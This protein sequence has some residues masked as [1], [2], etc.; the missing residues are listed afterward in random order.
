MRILRALLFCGT[1]VAMPC[2]AGAQTAGAP[3]PTAAGSQVAISGQGDPDQSSEQD[4]GDIVVTA[5]RRDERL[6]DVPVSVTALSADQLTQKR[7]MGAVDLTGSVP[8]LQAAPTAGDGTPIFSLRGI[9]MS[10]Y[11]V[12][13]QSPVATYFDEVYKGSFPLLPTGLFDL[14]RVE[15]LRGPQ[16]TLYGKNTT[17]GAINFISRKPKIGEFEG[18]LRL[19]YGNYDRYEAD[20]AVNVPLGDAL[21]FRGAFTFARADGWFHN[22]LPGRRD[23][24]ATRQYALRGSLLFEPSDALSFV[25]RASTSLDNPVIYGVLG[26]PLADGVGAGVYE[27]FGGQSYFR[28]G[29]GRRETASDY[30]GEYR[31]RT[32]GIALNANWKLS[33]ALAITSVTSYDYGK[34]DI[35]EDAD[36]SPLQ[37]LHND[38]RSVAK[39]FAQDLRLA[40]DFSS[41][42]NFILGGYYNVERLRAGYEYRY[43]N[44]I[45]VNQ[46]GAITFE[47]CLVDF[48]LSCAYRNKFKQK[49]TSVAAYADLNWE[50]ADR[51][52]L[53]GGLRYTHDT[54]RLSDFNSLLFGAD[55]VPIANVIPGGPDFD[56]T[57]GLAFKK[58]NLSGKIGVDFKPSANQLIY[59]SYSRGYRANAFNAQALFDIAELNVARP[60]TVDAYELGFKSQFLNRSLTINGAA[61]YYAYEN[62]QALSIDQASL[63]NILYNIPRSRVLGGELEISARITSAFR[64]NASAGYLDSKIQRGLLNGADIAGNRLPNAPKL[65]ISGGVEADIFSNQTGTLTAAVDASF[66]S[67]KYFELSNLE[68]LTQGKYALLNARITF[69]TLDDRFSVS[70]WGKNITNRYYYNSAVDATAVGYD[71]FHAGTPR[72]YGVSLEAKF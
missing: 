32:N 28:T 38:V 2:A 22:V 25:L 5:L 6:Q 69:A 44:D 3:G 57:T 20:G 60:E 63:L 35:G 39:Q 48:F 31:H 46:D 59:A 34:L 1:V 56:A 52:K 23:M 58:N 14:E 62:Q 4:G 49:K 9:S 54:G 13:Q 41:G 55:G 30:E 51:I 16:G 67:K 47:D 42:P 15:V 7:I 68:R 50:V 33:D 36:G 70:I 64:V 45:D 27:A 29:L 18:N 10:D 72:Q 12:N 8:N 40:S 19:G 71:Y 53:R 37:V 66:S 17:G 21:A 24:N 26:R 43:F 11:S 61:F 65:T